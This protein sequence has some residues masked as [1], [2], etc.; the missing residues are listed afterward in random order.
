MRCS[1]REPLQSSPGPGSIQPGTCCRLHGASP[2]AGWEDVDGWWQSGDDTAPD[3]AVADDDPLR[4]MYT[5]GTE[6]RPKGAMLSSRSLISQYVRCVADGGMSADDVEVHAL[7]MYHCAQLDCFFC[8]D[9]YLGATSIIMPGPDPATL[10]AAIAREQVTKLFCPPT[11]WISLLRH[12]DFAATDLS[13]L[14]TSRTG[15]PATNGPNTS[16]LLR[17]CRRTPAARSL[18]ENCA[19]STRALLTRTERN[20]QRRR[21]NPGLT[22]SAA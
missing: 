14:P 9:V 4:L 18:N 2:A 16:S 20:H 12:P 5:S 1:A 7:P 6:S 13:S 21:P 15:S 19:S 10:L 17:S 3:V 11:V 22:L 8:V